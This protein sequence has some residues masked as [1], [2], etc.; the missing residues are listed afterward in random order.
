MAECD[1]VVVGG[2]IAGS[3]AARFAAE[4]GFK[5]LLIEKLETPRNKPCSGIQF[6][7]LEKLVGTKIP[8]DKLCQNELN[9]VEIVTPGG[10]TVNGRMRMLNFWR[11]TFDSWLNSVA[12][13]AGAEFRDSTRLLDFE[14]ENGGFSLHL[15]SGR[16]NWHVH[17]RYLVA[18]D[19]LYSHMRKKL[20]PDDFLT[21]SAGGTMNY[22][23]VGETS[24]DP[25][26]LYMV[27]NRDLAPLMF[28]WA[29]LKDGEW[30]IGTGATE[31]IRDYAD[32]FFEYIKERYGFEGKIVRRE[33][34][35]SPLIGGV[36]LG[37][38]RL[39]F[40]GDAAGLVDLYRGLGMD[41][42]ALSARYAIKAI[43]AAEKSGRPVLEH[44][45]RL[46]GGIIRQLERNARRQAERYTSNDELERSLAP[47][48]MLKDGLLMLLANR[49]NSVLP[50]ERVITL[51]L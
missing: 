49:L 29:Y 15:Q 10:K 23:C 34:F 13:E 17:T 20:R 22:Y 39:L 46:M 40:V 4:R 32:R 18:A 25:H 30:A 5:T 51:P 21:K 26:T 9:R 41:N 33:G 31:R 12:A 16:D 14:E 36:Y 38:G 47:A 35:A 42:A 1:I 28:A 45:E 2:G 44:Y 37:Q 8:R 7:Y 27:Y 24:M 19:G 3:V 11:S 50:A 43:A 6:A 48:R